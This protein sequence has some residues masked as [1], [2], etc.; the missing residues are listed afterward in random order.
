[1][2]LCIIWCYGKPESC[3][4]IGF[5]IYKKHAS[6]SNFIKK[7]LFTFFEPVHSRK[8]EKRLEEE[9]ADLEYQIR[10]LMLKR[11]AARPPPATQGTNT[12][13]ETSNGDDQ[14]AALEEDLIKR[15]L[16]V[17]K[18]RDEIINCLELDR[19]RERQEDRSIAEHVT[20]YQ[21]VD[22]IH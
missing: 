3:Y 7:K 19:L 11:A 21:G 6:C 9:H 17:V 5:F 13:D 16:T 12:I 8:R 10:C 22:L 1:M 2:I 20:K 14:D 4:E 15:L 18:Q